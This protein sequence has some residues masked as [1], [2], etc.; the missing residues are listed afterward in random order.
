MLT[1]SRRLS[2]SCKSLSTLS[3]SSS[4]FSEMLYQSQ[5]ILR[6]F[7]QQFEPQSSVLD[8]SEQELLQA[9]GR[10]ESFQEYGARFMKRIELGEF[11]T[12]SQA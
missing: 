9:V 6:G 5:S 11:S 2:H 1:L 3:Q 7:P 12:L 8:D 4:P 10:G